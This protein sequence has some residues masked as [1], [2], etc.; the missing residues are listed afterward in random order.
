M[1]QPSELRIGNLIISD[2]DEFVYISS[3]TINSVE[4]KRPSDIF[5]TNWQTVFSPKPIPLTEEWLL[6]AGFEIR[7]SLSYKEYFIGTNEVTHDWLFSLTWINDPERINAI[8]APFFNNGRHT[9]QY[10]HQLQNLYFAL[11]GKELEF[12]L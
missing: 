3:I 1:I 9:I 2:L 8:N 5:T 12:K 7:E 6:K 11:T 10:V 4:G